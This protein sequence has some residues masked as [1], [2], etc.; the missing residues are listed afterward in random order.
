M[1]FDIKDHLL[2]DMQQVHP[3][4]P[5]LLEAECSCSN[6]DGN[7]DGLV[8]FS[9]D[10]LADIAV[11]WLE[12]VEYLD[13]SMMP[14]VKIEGNYATAKNLPIGTVIRA[15]YTTQSNGHWDGNRHV[16]TSG[17]TY[18]S[19]NANRVGDE[20]IPELIAK[21]SNS[22]SP[23]PGYGGMIVIENPTTVILNLLTDVANK[24]AQRSSEERVRLSAQ[25]S[26]TDIRSFV[27]GE[28]DWERVPEVTD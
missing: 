27:N 15:V 9:G 2:G 12:H 7:G 22:I 11:Q 23:F 4:A 10:S 24:E 5:N 25:R 20:R 13:D 16:K 18:A 3:L 1:K 14:V 21:G 8:R 17:A 26:L 28:E 6:P 19:L